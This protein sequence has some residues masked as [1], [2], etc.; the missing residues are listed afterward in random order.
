MQY[1]GTDAGCQF[2]LTKL[3]SFGGNFGTVDTVKAFITSTEHRQHFETDCSVTSQGAAVL[4]CPRVNAPVMRG[5]LDAHSARLIKLLCRELAG[6]QNSKPALDL[7]TSF[8][9]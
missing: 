1:Q 7:N 8:V 2:F 6:A 9:V 4:D 5:Q 3:N